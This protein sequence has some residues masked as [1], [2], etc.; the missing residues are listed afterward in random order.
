M[1]LVQQQI[2]RR[3]EAFRQPRAA[4]PAPEDTPE[5]TSVG[6]VKT[7]TIATPEAKT[8]QLRNT[9][10]DKIRASGYART[11]AVETTLRTVTSGG[12]PWAASTTWSRTVSA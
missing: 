8:T 4:I 9:M 5:T 6:T 11:P 10:L 3:R 2:P 7:D 12:E 1:H